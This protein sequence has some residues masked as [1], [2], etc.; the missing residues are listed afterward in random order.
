MPFIKVGEENSTEIKLYYEDR[1][2][3]QPVVLIHGYPSMGIR[4][5][6]KR[7]RYWRLAIASSPTTVVGLV[8]QPA[9][10]WL[11]L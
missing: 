5:R 11:R 10:E 7:P 2:S 9:F 8:S 4:G 1:R 6:N 3:G